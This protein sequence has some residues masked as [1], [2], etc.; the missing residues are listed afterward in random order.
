M[1]DLA[2]EQILPGCK[3]FKAICL[4]FMGSVT[5]QAMVNKRARM[6]V[7]PLILVC[8]ATGA[9]HTQVAHDYSTSAFL[10]QW[11]HFVAVRGRP[12]KVVS[13]RG[14]QLTSSNNTVKTDLINWEQV[15]GREARQETAWEFVPAGCQ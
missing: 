6:K 7:Y 1:G 12:T 14:S 4:D 2:V 8:Q 10:L 11:D 5:V 9:V 13:D 15:E 3:P